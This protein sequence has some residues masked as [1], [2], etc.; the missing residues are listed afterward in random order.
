MHTLWLD[1][2]PPCNPSRWGTLTEVGELHSLTDWHVSEASEDAE[3]ED[4]CREEASRQGGEAGGEER[5]DLV[6]GPACWG[7]SNLAPTPTLQD[8]GREPLQQAAA[9]SAHTTGMGLPHSPAQ[10]HIF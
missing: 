1:L 9:P 8:H 4:F 5:T 3:L 7:W 6:T 2:G 10:H